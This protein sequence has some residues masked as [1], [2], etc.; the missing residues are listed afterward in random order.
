MSGTVA[1]RV[2]GCILAGTEAPSGTRFSIGC[3]AHGILRGAPEVFMSLRTCAS[4]LSLM[5]ATLVSSVLAQ[6]DTATITG[7]VTDSTGAVIGGVQIK[8]VNK[9]TNF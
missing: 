5:V 7:R 4:I 2:T 9:E 3:P 6:V 8:I 1:D